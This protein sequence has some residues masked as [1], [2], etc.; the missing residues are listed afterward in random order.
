MRQVFFSFE[1][2]KDAWRASKIRNMGVVEKDST[3]S[4]NDWEEVKCKSDA[5]I[6]AWID[7]QMKMRSCIVVLVG[8]TTYSRKWVRYEIEKAYKLGKG[9]VG[10][11]VHNILDSN[12]KKC[13]KGNNPF[14]YVY[15][16]DG[17]ALSSYVKCYNSPYSSSKDTYD[18]I[19]RNIEDW[20]EKAI[21]NPA[22]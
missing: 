14:D 21:K 1:Y 9:I 17:N 16:D 18:Y 20:I 3:F 8:E 13:N 22:P 6:K 5:D 2:K 10:I 11:Y 7:S 4:D 19:K 15:A 12:F